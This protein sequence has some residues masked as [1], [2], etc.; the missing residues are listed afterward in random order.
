MQQSE[1][2]RIKRATV[3]FAVIYSF[4]YLQF[5][6]NPIETFVCVCVAKLFLP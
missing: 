1:K 2:A 3:W 6:V 5:A 4:Y